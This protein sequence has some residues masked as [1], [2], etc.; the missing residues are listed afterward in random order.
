MAI[1]AG[2]HEDNYQFKFFN[3]KFQMPNFSKTQNNY[4]SFD[5]GLVHF[6]GLNLHYFL[7]ESEN[8]SSRQAMLDWVEDDLKLVDRS[9][10]PWVIVFG[11]KMIYCNSSDC[12]GFAK[13]FS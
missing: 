9:V 7:G 2:N 6:V 10:T 4:F 1:I 12:E 5:L 11:H 3:E 8:S 13:D